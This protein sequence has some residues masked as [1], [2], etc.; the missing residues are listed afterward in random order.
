MDYQL[1]LQWK[2]PEMPDYDAM[3]ELENMI[4]AVLDDAAE[5]DGHD[6]GSGECNIFVFCVNPIKTFEILRSDL[7]GAEWFASVRAGFKQDEV[8]TYT[9]IWPKSLTAFSVL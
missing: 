1:V 3:I 9:P 7:N 8:A 6:M 5:V 4:I 2:V